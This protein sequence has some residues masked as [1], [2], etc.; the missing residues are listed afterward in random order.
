MK[1]ILILTG[2]MYFCLIACNGKVTK[3]ANISKETDSNT[4][5]NNQTKSHD[6]S[7]DN[8]HDDD[9][10]IVENDNDNPNGCKNS[11]TYSGKISTSK[12]EVTFDKVEVSIQHKQDI[13]TVE[14]GCINQVMVQFFHGSGCKLEIRADTAQVGD[15]GIK[16]TSIIFSADSQCPNFLDADE[17][18]YIEV[19]AL[20]KKSLTLA[21]MKVPDYNTDTSCHEQKIVISL[22]G[23]LNRKT[24]N[25]ELNISLST[26]TINGKFNS[27]GSTNTQCLCKA[28]CSNKCDNASD[29]CGGICE[30][31]SCTAGNMCSNFVCIDDPCDPDPCNGNGSCQNPDATCVCFEGYKGNSCDSCDAGYWDYPTCKVDACYNNTA[32]FAALQHINVT[33]KK[34]ILYVL[35]HWLLNKRL[36]QHVAENVTLLF[37]NVIRI[38]PIPFVLIH[39]LMQRRWEL[40]VANAILDRINAQLIILPL[41]V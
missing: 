26:L 8:T 38:T 3:S 20:D 35:I 40:H 11:Q 28:N 18:T 39:W 36:V 9:S 7:V 30:Q 2:M 19:S 14:D 21:L 41:N 33:V 4:S 34:Q 22:S 31:S 32:A 23:I 25:K 29:G 24:D 10:R 15:N 5:K 6:D 13:D 12:G 1:H 17:G 16:I 37:I 27:K